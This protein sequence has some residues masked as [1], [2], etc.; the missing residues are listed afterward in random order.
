MAGRGSLAYRFRKIASQW[1]PDKNG[2]LLPS[3]LGYASGRRVWWRCEKGHQWQAAVYSRT[4]QG[5]GCP[6]CSGRRISE[7]N[8]LA[9]RYPLLS[10]EWDREKNRTLTPDKVSPG[11]SKKVWWRCDHG[12]SWKTS[13]YERTS[14]SRC[15]YCSRRLA[16]PEHNLARSHPD[17]AA[18]WHP[19]KNRFLKADQVLPGSGKKV[20]WQCDKGHEWQAT[21]NSRTG[22][23]TECPY[24]VGRKA[25]RENNLYRANR[26]LAREWDRE[27]NGSLKPAEVTPHSSRLVWWLCPEGHSWEASVRNRMKGQNCPYCA[28][29]RASRQNSLLM[30]APRLARQWDREKNGELTP[31][32]VTSSTGR[33]VWWLC[34]KGH[35]YR[36]SVYSRVQKG[37]G[38]PYCAGKAVGEDN[39][40]AFIKPELAAEWDREKNGELTPEKVTPGSSKKVWWLCPEKGHSW[41]ASI[42]DRNGGRSCP[43]C[44]NRKVCDDN[45]LATLNPTLAAEWHG[46][47]NGADFT[48]DDVVP[49]SSFYAWWLCPVCGHEW[50][51]QIAARNR[52]T[53]C[54]ACYAQLRKEGFYRTER[55]PPVTFRHSRRK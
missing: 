23:N 54:P 29:R 18:Q 21:V 7:D 10:E 17:L 15:P 4:L 34:E 27:K 35:S 26:A 39:N 46:K 48:P 47:R 53:G 11:S 38:C 51:A 43:Y 25:S 9:A 55:T 6:Y 37:T 14:G 24:C 41:Q 36:A 33:K 50:K 2:D 45:S 13:V 5:S 42:R 8:S 12:H 16:S 49:G 31:G 44:K 30:K 3:D 40:L 32:Q 1:H 22:L 20:W 19:R 52:G 28:N